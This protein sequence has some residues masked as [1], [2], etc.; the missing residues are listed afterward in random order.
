MEILIDTN[1]FISYG[2]KRDNGL[3]NKIRFE[4]HDLYTSVI[5]LAE[6]RSGIHKGD[7]DF[8]EAV[9]ET[10]DPLPVDTKI[11]DMAGEFKYQFDRTGRNINI[12]DHLIA[13]TALKNGLTLVTFNKKDFP[14]KGL[15]LY[16]T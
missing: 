5:V 10:F 2:K 13:A 4:N 3:I 11:A 16:S 1:V 8:Y 14:H 15:K 9:K 12:T 6:L 7:V